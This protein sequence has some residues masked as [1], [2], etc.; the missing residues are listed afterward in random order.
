MA[1]APEDE[2][3]TWPENRLLEKDYWR[4]H[5]DFG[6]SLVPVW[7]SAR[8]AVADAYDGDYFGAGLN[9]ALAL[10]DLALASALGKGLAKVGLKGGLRL[11][12]DEVGKNYG[13]TNVRTKLG[14]AELAEPGQH[15]HHWLLH[16]NEGL[17]KYAPD[18]LKNQPWNLKAMPSPEVHQRIHSAWKGQPR[19]NM[20]DRYR[21]GV[22]TPAKAAQAVAVGHV[23]AGAR[24]RLEDEE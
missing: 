10:S 3:E 15:M 6:E 16:Q 9:G 11:A 21:Y 22:P 5:P 14:K 1:G 4:K 12:G 23:S 18:W 2:D 13:W 7:G 24:A 19:F 17:G 8:E 20:I